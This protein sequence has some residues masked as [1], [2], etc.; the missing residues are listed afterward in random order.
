M[1]T[2]K[3]DALRSLAQASTTQTAAQTVEAQPATSRAPLLFMISIG[4]FVLLFLAVTWRQWVPLAE[5]QVTRVIAIAA[6]LENTASDQAA[7]QATTQTAMQATAQAAFQA[8]G[9]VEAD[10]QVTQITALVSGVIASVH[11]V[12]GDSVQQNQIIAQLDDADYNLA[13]RLAENEVHAK[14]AL[15]QASK[16]QTAIAEASRETHKKHHLVADAVT[17]EKLDVL[18]RLREAAASISQGRL[19]QAELEYQTA[20]V[21]AQAVYSEH[22]IHEAKVREQQAQEKVAAAQLLIAQSKRDQAQLNL[23]RCIIRAPMDGMIQELFASPGR[24]QMLGSDNM[25]STTVATLYDPQKLQVRVDVAL[26]DAGG[27]FIGQATKITC[28]ALAGK[29][30]TGTVTRLLGVADISR[31]TI[32][33]KVRID[34]P[35]PLLRPDMLVKVQFLGKAPTRATTGTDNTNTNNASVLQCFLPA[36]Y[37]ANTPAPTHVWVVSEDQRIEQRP[38]SV[39]AVH[40]NYRHIRSGLRPGEWVIIDPPSGLQDGQRVQVTL[41]QEQQDD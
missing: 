8:A 10:P 23:D 27:L 6:A 1:D 41:K 21:R 12:D 19:N 3:E 15:V 11:V 36:Q 29:T 25:H 20:Q 28:S 26:D 22:S 17:A 16:Q 37:I 38:I 35:V 39:G 4:A 2:Q 18:Q 33:A 5:V 7:T 31:N 14:Q 40:N 30:F 13:L 32:Q 9:W 34:N 24:K